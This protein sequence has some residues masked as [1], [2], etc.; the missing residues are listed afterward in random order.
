MHAHRIAYKG[1]KIRNV[2]INHQL[3]AV[4]PKA[5]YK[6]IKSFAAFQNF[7]FVFR[8]KAVIKKLFQKII[9][10]IYDFANIKLIIKKPSS[11]RRAFYPTVCQDIQLHNAANK[12]NKK[13]CL[14]HAI[15][16]TL[17][18]ASL[19]GLKSGSSPGLAS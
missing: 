14:K 11:K 18:I 17:Y 9:S 19:N 15:Y 2:F 13:A 7:C 12:H 3:H 16:P 5:F 6:F 1:L 10:Y 8:N 4:K